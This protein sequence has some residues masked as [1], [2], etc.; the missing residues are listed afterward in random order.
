MNDALASVDTIQIT[1]ASAVRMYPISP[2]KQ[3][4]HFISN[5]GSH[6]G[7]QSQTSV[8][9]SSTHHFAYPSL[10]NLMII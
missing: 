2:K 8:S 1:E 4:K 5:G 3:H 10:P 6:L 7:S 9:H